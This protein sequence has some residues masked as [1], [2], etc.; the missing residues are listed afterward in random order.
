MCRK[1]TQKTPTG[2]ALRPRLLWGGGGDEGGW[3]SVL[4]Y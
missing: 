2:E 1:H 3:V 4:K